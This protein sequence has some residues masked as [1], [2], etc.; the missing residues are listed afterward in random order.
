[1]SIISPS[2]FTISVQF[3]LFKQCPLTVQLPKSVSQRGVDTTYFSSV[4]LLTVEA[5]L[6]CQKF[7]FRGCMKGRLQA[8]L[9][10]E[11]QNTSY[12]CFFLTL[13]NLRL[14]LHEASTKDKA[15]KDRPLCS[16]D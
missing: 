6:P 13:F 7:G 12:A 14:Y 8:L 11:K 9:R 2:T 16:Q 10:V 5:A 15:V 1:M 4:S 3:T